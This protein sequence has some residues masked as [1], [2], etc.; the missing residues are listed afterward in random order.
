MNNLP[1]PGLI[2]P[3]LNP[4][5][6]GDGPIE[7]TYTKMY[8]KKSSLNPYYFGDG[9]IVFIHLLK[10]YSHESLNPY[11]FGDGPIVTFIKP[12]IKSDIKS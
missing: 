9:P 7:E 10:I 2:L 5:Y 6:F 11:Y 12:I 1:S 3:S 8:V 4:Y